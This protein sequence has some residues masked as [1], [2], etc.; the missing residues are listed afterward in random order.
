MIAPPTLQQAQFFFSFALFLASSCMR[1]VSVRRPVGCPVCGLIAIYLLTALAPSSRKACSTLMLFLALDSKNNMF[2]FCWQNLRA[3]IVVTLRYSSKST[4]LPMTRNGNVS[5]F[6]G[7]DFVRKTCF[8][9]SKWSKL[10]G[11][12]TS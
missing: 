4:L 10:A 3:S 5:I 11:F 8:Q 1:L 9:S 6:W 2:P 7:C 12:V